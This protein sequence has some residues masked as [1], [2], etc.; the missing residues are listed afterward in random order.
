MTSTGEVACLGN[1][2]KEAFLKSLLAAEFKLPNKKSVLVSIGGEKNRYKLLSQIK[3]LKKQGYNIYA[4]EH[5]YLFLKN[6]GIKCTRLYKVHEEKHP[7]VINYI[8]NKRLGLIINIPD[9]H[10]QIRLDDTYTIRRAAVDYSIPL[11][12]NL[13]LADLFIEC[14]STLKLTDLEVKSWSEYR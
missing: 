10:K 1:N 2:H 13:Q 9:P 14:I 6:N 11:I 3:L 12:T 8:M 7:N 4:T 5:T